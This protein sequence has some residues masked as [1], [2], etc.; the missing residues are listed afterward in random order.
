MIIY[1]ENNGYQVFPGVKW[2]GCGVDH[3]PLSSADIKER[4]ELYIYSQTGTS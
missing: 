1:F 3:P 4:V 2:P